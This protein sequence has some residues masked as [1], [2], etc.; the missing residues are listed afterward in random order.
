MLEYHE[1]G[2]Q[3]FQM[4]K[5]ESFVVVESLIGSLMD[6][7]GASIHELYR[8][9]IKKPYSVKFTQAYSDKVTKYFKIMPDQRDDDQFLHVKPGCSDEPLPS[10]IDNAQS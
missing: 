2:S 5:E 10:Q 1:P 7:V 6:Q 9:S 3:R 8:N 4:V